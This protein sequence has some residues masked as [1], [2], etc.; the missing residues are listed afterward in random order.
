MAAREIVKQ[1]E[2][3][4]YYNDGTIRLTGVRVSFPH[5]VT[6]QAGEDDNGNPT[7]AK[8][9]IVAMLPKETHEE[10]YNLCM[11]VINKM[12]KDNDTKVSS[13]KFFLRDGDNM[14]REE[15][16]GFWI[17]SASDDRRPALRDEQGALLDMDEDKELA[18]EMFYGGCWCHV[19]IRPWYQDGV[20]HG[21]GKGKRINSGLVAV[22]KDRD[23]KSFGEGRVD[24]SDV[25]GDVAKKGG[26]AGASKAGG[27]KT[28]LDDDDEP[29]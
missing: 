2:N 3:A 29:L 13:D 11:R 19:F 10:A 23:D 4:T 26:K 7:K 22:M 9:K 21:K 24:D 14:D 1:V 12:I 15:Y 17:V 25:W 5:L 18:E 8:F 16:E 28:A 6:P 20:K 27:K